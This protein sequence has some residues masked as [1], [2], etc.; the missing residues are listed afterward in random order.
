MNIYLVFL[1][2]I[3]ISIHTDAQQNQT[4]CSTPEASQFDFWVGEWNLE[5]Q[6]QAGNIQHGNNSIKKILDGC[7]I[8]ENFTGAGT[9]E[10]KGRSLSVF[11]P[12]AGFW[13]QT[14]VDNQGG[15]LDFTG[16]FSDGR[17]IL[18]RS[19]RTKDGKEILQRM[20]FYDISKNSFTWDWENS[21]NQGQTWNLQ[22]KIGYT[23]KVGD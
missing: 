12:V 3:F 5:W 4:P 22:W 23:R 13:Q 19:F 21:A 11:N 15:Y 1:A 18:S 9:P 2:T 20:V 14:W 8:E 6:D 16:R 10:F 17:M 7:V